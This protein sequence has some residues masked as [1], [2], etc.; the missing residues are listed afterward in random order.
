MVRLMNQRHISNPVKRF[1]G[2]FFA[3]VVKNYPLLNI[4]AKKAPS[5]M[6]DLVL[7]TLP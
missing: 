4:F 7:N 6:F 3:K 2:I 1:Q 5:S